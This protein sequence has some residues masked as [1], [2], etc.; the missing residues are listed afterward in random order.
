M[1]GEKL[2]PFDKCLNT[3][4]RL[5]AEISTLSKVYI[6][7]YQSTETFTHR[8]CSL[9]TIRNAMIIRVGYRARDGSTTPSG[10]RVYS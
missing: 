6:L 7:L 2:T 8:N 3:A 4:N 10:S 1:C 9:L 5:L